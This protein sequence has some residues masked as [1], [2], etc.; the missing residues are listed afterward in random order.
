MP[1]LLR[2]EQAKGSL[3]CL[4]P[5]DDTSSCIIM[6]TA[7]DYE[8]RTPE[9]DDLATEY[10]SFADLGSDFMD[11]ESAQAPEA[12]IVGP[13]TAPLT[14]PLLSMDDLEPCVPPTWLSSSKKPSPPL[15]P[16]LSP[17]VSSSDLPCVP[18]PGI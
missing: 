4:E 9:A 2:K 11:V 18:D 13:P 3:D 14:E 15:P 1:E 6:G 17:L 10:V 16:F 7:A 5:E 8:D 12:L